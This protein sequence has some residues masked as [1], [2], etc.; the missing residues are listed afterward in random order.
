LAHSLLVKKNQKK[1]NKIS[2]Q[3]FG[4]IK[5]IV[6]SLHCKKIN[7]QRKNAHIETINGFSPVGLDRVS[8]ACN[9]VQ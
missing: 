3:L 7:M 2:F 8:G 6:S 9:A 5:K 4:N 1:I